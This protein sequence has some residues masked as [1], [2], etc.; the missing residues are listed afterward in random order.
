MKMHETRV[1]SLLNFF[2]LSN[3]ELIHGLIG[4]HKYD[5][6]QTC[7]VLKEGGIIDLSKLDCCHF[8]FRTR[9]WAEWMRGILVLKMY[10]ANFHLSFENLDAIC[11]ELFRIFFFV[12]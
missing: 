4:C 5:N 6:V 3:S 8:E 2:E 1:L 7:T 9:H 11:K 12:V 10:F